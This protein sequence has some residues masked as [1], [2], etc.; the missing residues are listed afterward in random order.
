MTSRPVASPRA[1]TIRACEWPPSRPSATLAVDL[2]EVGAPADQLADPL[3]CLADDHLDDLGVA[4]PLAGGEGV[5]DV[6][7]EVVLGVE[8]AGDPALGVVAVAL[9]DL[10]LGDDQDAELVGD[11]ERRAEAGDAAADDQDVGEVVGQLAGVEADE[12]ATREGKRGEHDC[13]DTTRKRRKQIE[14]PG[15]P[16]KPDQPGTQRGPAPG[17]AGRGKADDAAYWPPGEGVLAGAGLETG[18][19]FVEGRDLASERL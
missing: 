15:R 8:D 2:V 1:W 7:V 19:P 14:D 4:Q 13:Y 16:G 5:G 10:V 9:A 12:V 18:R 11:A 3:G 6:V 17:R